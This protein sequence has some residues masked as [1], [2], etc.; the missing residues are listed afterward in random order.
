M[1]LRERLLGLLGQSG[2]PTLLH[3][4]RTR[5]AQHATNPAPRATCDATGPQQHA[6]LPRQIAADHATTDA[7]SAQPCN[8][9]CAT[10]ELRALIEAI[11]R[12]CDARGDLDAN[13][14]GLIDECRRLPQHHQVD[15]R[16][17]FAQEAN[18]WATQGVCPNPSTG[19]CLRGGAPRAL[20]TSTHTRSREDVNR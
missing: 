3:V 9:E 2:D 15:L 16:E 12:C 10:R 8:A 11:N 18:R 7:T 14:Q 19:G 6:T 4:A 5:G 17:H 20:V 13:R 1:D